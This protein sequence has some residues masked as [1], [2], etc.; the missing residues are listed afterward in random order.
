MKAVEW[1]LRLAVFGTFCGHGLIA[2]IEMPAK[3]LDYLAIV[4]V[5]VDYRCNLLVFIGALDLALALSMLIKPLKPVLIYCVIWALATALMRPIAGEGVLQFVERMVNFLAP[6][7]LYL[8]IR[9]S[10]I[11]NEELKA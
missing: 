5:P 4:G 10:S 9:K 7:A 6:M 11:H 3:W 1:A 2:V 8:L